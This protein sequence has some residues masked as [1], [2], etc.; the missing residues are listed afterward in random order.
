MSLSRNDVATHL[1]EYFDVDN[2][3]LTDSMIARWVSSGWVKIARKVNNW[4]AYQ[5]STELSTVVGQ[6]DYPMPLKMLAS[7]SERVAYGVLREIDQA[8]GERLFPPPFNVSSY[9]AYWSIWNGL[10]R[11]WP[12]PN[13]VYLLDVR[14]YRAPVNPLNIAATDAIDLP[15]QDAEDALILWCIFQ[16]SLHQDD[17]LRPTVYRKEFEEMLRTVEFDAVADHEGPI[18]LNSVSTSDA[19]LLP[20]RLRFPFE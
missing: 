14:G 20:R 15:T 19:T 16:A 18:V 7:V 13:A 8:T 1:R 4:P 5:T 17:Y 11:I 10:L 3:E 6:K 9:P 12:T 2:T